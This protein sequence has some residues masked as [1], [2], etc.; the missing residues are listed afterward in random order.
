VDAQLP[1]AWALRGITAVV[2]LKQISLPK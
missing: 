2:A 1:I